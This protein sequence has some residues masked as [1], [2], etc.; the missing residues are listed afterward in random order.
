MADKDFRVKLGLHV[1]A[2]AYIEG[3]ISSVDR[4][5]M[6]TASPTAVSGAGQLAWNI[7]E[8][9]VDVGMNANTTLQLGQ[10]TYFYVK[11]HTANTIP[12]GTAVMANGTNG[13]SGRIHAEPAVANG[14]VPSKYILGITT[15][16]IAAG[17]DGFVTAFGKVRNVNTSMFSEGDILYANP[18]TPGGLSNTAPLAPNNIVTLAIVINKHASTGTLFVRPTYGSNFNENEDVHLESVSDGQ[19]IVYVT[20][21]SRFENKTVGGTSSDTFKTISVAGQSNVVADSSTDTLT[22]VAGSG[23]TITTDAGTDTITF[24][25]TGGGDAS[26]AWVNANDYATLLSA[27]ANDYATLLTAQANDYNTLITAQANDGATIASA[28]A[29]DY[30]TYTTLVG[31]YKANDYNTLITAQ[32]NDYNTLIT[33]Q[34]NDYATLLTARANDYNTYTTLVGEYKANDYNTLLTAQANDYTTYTTLVG[35]YKAND[36]N[37]L[38]TAQANDGVTIASARANDYATYTTLAGEYKAND[39]NT[40]LTAQANDY[41]TLLS[42]Y[43]NDT[44]LY[45]SIR[46]FNAFVVAGQSDVVADGFTD[47]V[48]LVAGS[49]MTITT[50]AATDTITFVSAGGG[51]GGDASNAW[52]NAN[53]YATLLSAYANDHALYSGIRSFNAFVVA[54]QSDVVADAFTDTV[55]LVA[56]S[57]MTITTN[58]TTDTITFASTGGGGSEDTYARTIAFLG[59]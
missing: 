31:E 11:N 10:E 43:A 20:A 2:N 40:L 21:N 35:E 29:N 4:I 13:A 25:S 30:A 3:N 53:D 41:T 45:S 5:Q 12:D 55:T 57:G 22:F 51:G 9:T 16:D 39:Y 7:D 50:D 8:S 34:A 38:L 58:S 59:L 49:G 26:N 23:M 46:S 18:G 33:T 44:A 37:T 17:E 52:V 15:E 24:A 1:G 54:G 48:T 6:N 47:T 27:Y 14:T 56:G 32:A 36:Y 19:A 28:R 42:A